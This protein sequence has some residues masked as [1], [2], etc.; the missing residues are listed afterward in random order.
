MN[1]LQFIRR[2]S[3]ASIVASLLIGCGGPSKKQEKLARVDD[4]EQN[5]RIIESSF[6]HQISAGT[7]MDRTIYPYHFTVGEAELNRLGEE[8]VDQLTEGGATRSFSVN[9][10]QGNVP[11]E[12]HQARVKAVRARLVANGIGDDKIAV[13]DQRPGA[14]GVATSVMMSFMGEKGDDNLWGYEPRGSTA[15]AKAESNG[16]GR[17]GSDRSSGGNSGQ[18]G[19]GGSAGG[20]GSY[21]GGS[22]GGGGDSSGR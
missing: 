21:G 13:V 18:G 4:S 10:P 20:G 17:T 6:T 7:R 11:A 16:P 3:A 5:Q 12:L 8:Q 22:G 15:G 19:G 14:S 2:V 1:E 9:I